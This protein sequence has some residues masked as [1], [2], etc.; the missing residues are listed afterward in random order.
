MSK[1]LIFSDIHF[2]PWAY[3]SHITDEGINSRLAAQ[4]AAADEMINDAVEEGV[5]H[6][7]FC[8][9]LFHTHGNVPTQAL[10]VAANMFQKLRNQGISVRAIP[11]N[12]DQYD[13]QGAIHGLQF[14]PESER[15]GHWVDE[16]LDVRSLPYT[17]DDEVLKRFLGEAGDG[18]GSMLLLHQGVSGIPLSSGYVLDERLTADMIPDNCRAF[19]GHYHFHKAV[20]P[21]LTVV[22]N[23]TPLGWGDIDQE[24]GWLIWDDAGTYFEQKIQTTS[25]EFVTYHDVMGD[26][27]QVVGRFVRYSKAIYYSEQPAVR[28]RL[29][30]A[31]A[32]SVEF[33]TMKVEKS[34]DNIRTGEGITAEHI[35]EEF[36]KKAEGR[37]AEIGV[38]LRESTYQ[39]PEWRA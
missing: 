1:R 9:D 4:A 14:L 18:D 16:G 32:L 37:R 39:T 19:T 38:E 24:K 23:L 26:M 5:K 8:G 17:D 20:T 36:D 11:G 35:A 6:A 30:K 7:Y 15:I 29:I 13:R 3:G 22:G 12:H 28:E 31:G 34:Q 27:T 25:P 33:P 2:H 10:M 21:K